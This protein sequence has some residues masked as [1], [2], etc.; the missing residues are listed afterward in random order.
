MSDAQIT[1]YRGFQITVALTPLIGGPVTLST[2]VIATDI[3]LIAALRT[4][5]FLGANAWRPNRAA[6]DIEQEI[7]KVKRTIDDYFESRDPS[8]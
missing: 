4:S 1:N 7:V 6:A 8:E 3:E 2:S 5:V